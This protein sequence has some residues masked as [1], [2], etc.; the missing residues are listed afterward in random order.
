M[1]AMPSLAAARLPRRQLL[2]LG[3]MGFLGLNVPRLLQAEPAAA[4]RARARSVIFLY[5]FGGPSQLDMF[6]MKPAAPE[7]IRGPLKPAATNVPGLAI[8]EQLPRVAQVMDKVTLLRAVH[9]SMKNHNSAAY[10]ALTGH[11]P[12]L[13]DIRLRDSIELFPAYGSVVDHLSPGDAGLPTFVAYPHVLR[14]GEVT[15]GQHASFLGKVHDPLLITEDPNREDFRLPE[16]SLPDNL[17][18]G[19]LENRRELQQLVDRQSR[20][21][22]TSAAARGLDAY[23]DKVLSMLN[24]PRVSQAFDLSAEPA[25]LRDRYGRH[26]YGQS[27]LLARRLVEAGVRFVNVY[28]SDSIGGQSP[29]RGGWDTHGFNNTRMYPIIEKYH[30]PITDQTLPTLLTDLDERGLL[31]ETLV[32]WMGEFGRTPKINQNISRDHWPDCYTVLLA[33]GGVKRGYVH[34]ASDK[35]AAF[36]DRDGVRPDDLAATM[37]QLL[38]IDPQTEVRDSAG[39]PLV[40]AS[41]NPISEI[42]A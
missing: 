12:P 39:R 19:R 37:F 15:P 29:R 42:V 13:D 17:S 23:Y 1:F 16:L 25:A 31:D 2:S 20:L 36:P 33:G 6:D 26:T 30:L 4:G 3:G 18:L 9:H 35:N 40:I 38:G 7:G 34:G 14:D 21:L 22:E 32:V 27:C 11:A 8:C 28:F 41:G 10:Y 5:Q 24:S